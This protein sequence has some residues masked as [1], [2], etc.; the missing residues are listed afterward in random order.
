M[1]FIALSA[2][3]AESYEGM[4]DLILTMPYGPLP[5]QLHAVPMLI[6]NYPE[7]KSKCEQWCGAQLTQI[8]TWGGKEHHIW[9]GN[10]DMPAVDLSG[11]VEEP[12][13]WFPLELPLRLLKVYGAPGITVWDGFMGRGTVGKA[14]Q[15]L[16]MH[17]V[18]MDKNPERVRM[19]RDY[20]FGE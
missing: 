8:G 12:E 1:T 14:C 15:Q 2:G 13:G 6:T 7:R 17:F 18:G 20:V 11:L 10:F 16:G 19:A 4:A 5:A 9:A 3:R